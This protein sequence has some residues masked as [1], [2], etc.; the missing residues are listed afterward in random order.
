MA[1]KMEKAKIAMEV[2][3]AWRNMDPPGRFLTRTDPTRADGFWH[4]VGTATAVKRATKTLGERSQRERRAQRAKTTKGAPTGEKR[5]TATAESTASCESF[6]RQTSSDSL[7]QLLLSQHF[8]IPADTARQDGDD[9]VHTEGRDYSVAVPQ[10]DEDQRYFYQQHRCPSKTNAILSRTSL[11]TSP[12]GS[13]NSSPILRGFGSNP[14]HTETDE[15]HMMVDCQRYP[16][17]CEDPNGE[18]TASDFAEWNSSL[19]TAAYLARTAFKDDEVERPEH[20]TTTAARRKA[21]DQKKSHSF[22]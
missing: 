3:E 10:Q 15:M 12:T 21:S 18:S 17:E 8:Q 11:G 6:E 22:P 14:K 20:K 19:P 1:S 5:G 7:D 9:Q 2:V 13:P 16:D 4:D